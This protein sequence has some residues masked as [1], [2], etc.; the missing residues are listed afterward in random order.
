ML[1]NMKSQMFVVRS[2]IIFIPLKYFIL[3]LIFTFYCIKGKFALKES[4]II[5]NS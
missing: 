3:T 2:F 5:K 4:L 1:H